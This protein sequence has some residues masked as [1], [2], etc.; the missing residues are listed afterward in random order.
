[1]KTKPTT[2][3][4]KLTTSATANNK[5]QVFWGTSSSKPISSNRLGG[6]WTSPYWNP[7]RLL[8]PRISSSLS[9]S[10]SSV[11]SPERRLSSSYLRPKSFRSTLYQS[12][13]SFSTYSYRRPLRYNYWSRWG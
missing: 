11:R 1:M 9:S 12:S 3:T 5:R 8:T 6:L 10:S 4:S 2:L 7:K 13:P